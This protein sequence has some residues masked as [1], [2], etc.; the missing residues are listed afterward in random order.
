M[1]ASRAR[2]I[3]SL[4]WVPLFVATSMLASS[5]VSIHPVEAKNEARRAGKDVYAKLEEMRTRWDRDAIPVGLERQLFWDDAVIAGKSSNLV[6]RLGW[7]KQPFDDGRCGLCAKGR[8][9]LG[10]L[11]GV[12]PSPR[13]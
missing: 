10:G 2:D 11:Q 9:D 12:F 7:P 13:F 1:K 6:R 8:D 4:L 3:K 5:C